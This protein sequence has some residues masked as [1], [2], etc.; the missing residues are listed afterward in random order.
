MTAAIAPVVG[1]L[2]AGHLAAAGADRLERGV[3]GQRAGGH[4]R[5]VLAEAVAHHHVGLD[6]VGGEQ[7]G[8]GEVG[9]QHGRLGDLGLQQLLLEPRRPRPG[10]CVDE[11]VVGQRPAEQRR[12]DPV[13]LGERLAPRSARVARSSS[14]MLTYCEP[15]PV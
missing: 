8:E 6:A 13:G 14:S 10:R 5:A 12:H 1:D 3:E 4:E 15:W 11:D 2:E 7:P 9:G